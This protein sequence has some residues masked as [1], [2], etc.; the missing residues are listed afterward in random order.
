MTKVPLHCPRMHFIG[1]ACVFTC[2]LSAI[3]ADSNVRVWSVF[4]LMMLWLEAK[5]IKHKLS[6]YYSFVIMLQ[7][8]L[9]QKQAH[10]N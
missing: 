5:V 9:P 1:R 8:V 10:G 7:Y 4:H 3:L 2:L 6:T